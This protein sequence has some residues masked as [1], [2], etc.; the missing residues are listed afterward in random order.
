M[1]KCTPPQYAGT[2][3]HFFYRRRH[4]MALPLLRERGVASLLLENPFYGLRKPAAQGIIFRGV[5][6]LVNTF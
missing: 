2:G 1:S 6:L 3:D 5:V 4:L